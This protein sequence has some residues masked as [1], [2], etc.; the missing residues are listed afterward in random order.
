MGNKLIN[1]NQHLQMYT[2]KSKN[3]IQ[4]YII[5]YF[6]KTAYDILIILQKVCIYNSM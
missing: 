5:N 1:Y 6:I 4:G 2:W 3:Y